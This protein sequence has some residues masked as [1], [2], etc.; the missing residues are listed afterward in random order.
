M[1]SQ[2]QGLQLI[3]RTVCLFET[4]AEEIGDGSLRSYAERGLAIM[5]DS[6]P[7][8]RMLDRVRTTAH[9]VRTR[10]DVLLHEHT[11]SADA[12]R[13][14]TKH[15]DRLDILIRA[16]LY[17]LQPDRYEFCQGSLMEALA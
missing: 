4:A 14:A 7:V 13:S 17:L 3:E 11:L 16:A 2:D 1:I 8:D 9:I 6:M 5:S 15:R 10:I 12:Y